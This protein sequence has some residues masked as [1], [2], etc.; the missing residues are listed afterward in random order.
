MGSFVEGCRGEI[1]NENDRDVFLRFAR[2]LIR[3]DREPA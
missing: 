3:R 1:V 2:S